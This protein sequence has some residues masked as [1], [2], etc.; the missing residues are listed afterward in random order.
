VITFTE[1][2]QNVPIDDKQ[3]A[4]PLSVGSAARVRGDSCV[5]TGGEWSAAVRRI[6]NK[7]RIDAAMDSSDRRRAGDHCARG[8]GNHAGARLA[9]ATSALTDLRSVDELRDLFNKDSGQVRIV[10]LLSPT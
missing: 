7:G 9:A 3:F 6:G 8:R 1:I 10:L 5:V 2:K 4:P